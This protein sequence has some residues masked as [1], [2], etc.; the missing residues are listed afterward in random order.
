MQ[1]LLG[2]SGLMQSARAFLVRYLRALANDGPTVIF[3]EDIHWSDDPSLDLAA[4][5]ATAIP[6]AQLLIVAV[7]RPSLFERRP[8][9]GEGQAAFRRIPLTPLSRRTSQM[10]IRDRG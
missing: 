8:N 3:L 7:T 2:D 6:E 5:L 4:Y 9:W 10:C 1:R